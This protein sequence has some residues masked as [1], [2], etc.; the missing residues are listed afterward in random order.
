MKQD[1]REFEA[2]V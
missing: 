2:C 1:M